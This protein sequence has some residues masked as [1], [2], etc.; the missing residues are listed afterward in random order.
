MA[1]V[2]PAFRQ[3]GGAMAAT[4]GKCRGLSIA[5]EEHDDFLA[6]QGERPWPIREHLDRHGR[7]PEAAKNLLFGA[8]H[9]ASSRGTH[10]TGGPGGSPVNILRALNE[11]GRHAS[12]P[13]SLS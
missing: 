13:T 12:V 1:V 3:L 2:A 4:I 11:H 10:D 9:D 8:E 5:V 7:I 6:E